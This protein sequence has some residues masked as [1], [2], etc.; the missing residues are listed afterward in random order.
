MKRF[1]VWIPLVL[2]LAWFFYLFLK[3]LAFYTE[4]FLR[5][6]FNYLAGIGWL[7]ISFGI[8]W[9]SEKAKPGKGFL[10]GF[11]FVLIGVPIILAILIVVAKRLWHL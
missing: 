1:L 3:E 11:F 7:A 5:V 2:I 10:I 4:E 9:V 6:I 8:G